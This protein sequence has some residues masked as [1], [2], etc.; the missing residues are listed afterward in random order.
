MNFKD[1]LQEH[2]V[3]TAPLGHD[4]TRPGWI[5]IDCPWC[6][7][8]SHKFYM[9]YN[10]KNGCLNCWY[11]GH[12]Q[13]SKTIAELLGIDHGKAIALTKG[14]DKGRVVPETKKMGKL[15]LPNGIED[16]NSSVFI[17]YLHSRGFTKTKTERLWKVKQMG[18]LAGRLSWRLFIPIHLHGEIISWTTRSISDQHKHRYISASP[19]EEAIPHKNLLYG[20]DFCRHVCLVLEGPLDVWRFG[21]GA[22]GTFG[23]VVSPAQVSRI[24][25]YPVRAVCFDNEFKAQQQADKLIDDLSIFPGQTY[26][27]ELDAKDPGEATRKEIKKVKDFLRI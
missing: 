6:S 20:E 25:K 15:I 5:N 22:V 3:R 23:T 12:Q 24:A 9:G 8:D 2:N 11:C 19:G 1:L 4:H 14:L 10:L 27:I 7:R 16:I 26:K 13:L 17:E 21:R 18:I